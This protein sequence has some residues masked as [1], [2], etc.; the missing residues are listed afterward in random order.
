MTDYT[1]VVPT[2]DRPRNMRRI[3]SLFPS[4]IV[5]VNTSN[6][7]LFRDVV[8]ESQLLPHP[9]MPL[10]ETRNWILDNI[11]TE[12]VLQFND[13][14]QFLQSMVGPSGRIRD[15][16]AIQ[17]VIENTIQC[18]RDLEL[19]V[20]CWSLTSNGG[21]L[22]P[23]LRPI[24]AAAPCSAHA[25][26]VRGLARERRFSTEFRGCGDFDFTM[27]TLR[28]D[29]LLYC[30]VRWHFDCGGMSRGAGGQTGKLSSAELSGAQKRLREK[31]GQYVGKS[32]TK[33]V[34][35]RQGWRDFSVNVRRSSKLALT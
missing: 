24:R 25:F 23:H 9:D 2:L 10:I 26:G 31:W 8:P 20:F 4:A 32:K 21:L 18:C 3:L 34:E 35:K 22:K 16:D 17:A 33:R 5:T 1:I 14:V 28:Q 19:G 12:C 30:D 29:R 27:E 13:D 6:L 7:R 11:Q 15:P